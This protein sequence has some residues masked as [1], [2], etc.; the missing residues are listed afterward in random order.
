MKG[1]GRVE[2]HGGRVDFININKQSIS[3]IQILGVDVDYRIVDKYSSH[4]P[5]I[6]ANLHI[7]VE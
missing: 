2:K 4:A 5:K 3:Y 7:C 1:G 6:K